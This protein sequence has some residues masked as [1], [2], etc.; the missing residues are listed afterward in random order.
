MFRERSHVK[1]KKF[2]L[3]IPFLSLD[4]KHARCFLEVHELI[5]LKFGCSWF[6]F[7]LL[8][9]LFVTL[10]VPINNGLGGQFF[11]PDKEVL[12]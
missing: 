8:V 6:N 3:L 10:Q 7:L 9:K 11:L 1:S 5:W 12:I 4:G 2:E